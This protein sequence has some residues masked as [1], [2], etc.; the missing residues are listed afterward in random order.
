M[1]DYFVSNTY[2]DWERIGSPYDKNGKLYQT[3]KCTCDRCVK[4]V[5]ICRVENNQPVPHPAYEGVCLKCGGSGYLTKEVRLYT[6]K[7]FEAKEKAAA[8][9]KEKKAAELEAKMKAE[10]A[11]KKAE[12]ME[13]NGFNAEGATYIITGDSYSIKEELKEAGWKFDSVLLWHKA[14]PAGYEDRVMKFYD[15]ELI[16]Y[17]AWGEGH[18]KTGAKEY[19]MQRMLP[20]EVQN[21]TYIGEI[22]EKLKKV[23]VTY[24]RHNSFCGR[25]GLTNIYEFKDGDMNHLVWFTAKDIDFEIGDILYLDG[26]V[27]EH[28][29]YNGIPQTIVTRCKLSNFS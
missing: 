1:T 15:Y 7:E 6:A 16:E 18:F 27:K 21:L 14:D 9:T 20:V 2:K 19:I 4:G 17:S 8:R 26:T 22:G 13:K 12:W 24:T 11:N 23:P 29:D 5:Y 3:V 25:Y 28:K 10:Y